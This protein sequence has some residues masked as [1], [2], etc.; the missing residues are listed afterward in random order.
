[1]QSYPRRARGHLF[2]WFEAFSSDIRAERRRRDLERGCRADSTSVFGPMASVINCRHD[3][4]SIFV[5]PSCAV[6]GQSTT[7]PQG[8]RIVLAEKVF[9]G[10][11]SRVW[12]AASITIGRHVLIAHGVNIYDNNSHY[13]R[14]QERR[15]EIDAILPGLDLISHG[16]DIKAEPIVIEDDVWIGF[17]AMV[18]GGV[19]IGRGAVVGAG[20]FVNADVPPF[21]IVAGNPMRIVKTLDETVL[22]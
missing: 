6:M 18:K 3:P 5:G 12:S 17:N 21:G 13:L 4:D 2:L 7:F 19:R 1:M 11:G 22:A 10:E 16:H 20:T 8:G 9:V 15:D 14:W